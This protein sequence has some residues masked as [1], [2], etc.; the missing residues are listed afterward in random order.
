MQ[1]S[2]TIWSQALI[3]RKNRGTSEKAHSAAAGAT[4]GHKSAQRRAFA[5]E[6]DLMSSS[7]REV[8]S[9][10]PARERARTLAPLKMEF[11]GATISTDRAGRI[12]T[13]NQAAEQLLGQRE[14]AVRGLNLHEVLQSRDIFGNRIACECGVRETLRRGE[15]VHRHVIG[16]ANASGESMRIVLL[17]EPQTHSSSAN[18]VYEVR[19]DAR[20]SHGDRRTA[21]RSRRV[22]TAISTL[23]PA[24]LK[25]LQLLAAG[26]RPQDAATSLGVSLTTVRNHVQHLYRKLGV[27]TQAEAIS[28]AFRGG[29]A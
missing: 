8:G 7:L 1:T 19:P 9:R 12:V 24:E 27:H 13:W 6:R 18:L 3:A 4:E 2:F 11:R 22:P 25:V 5:P 17:I 16:V 20:R 15:P 29:V 26:K 23:T 10:P 21:D 28:A 14:S